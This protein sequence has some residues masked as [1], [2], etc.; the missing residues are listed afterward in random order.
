MRCSL[1]SVA[2][3]LLYHPDLV[4]LLSSTLR[5]CTKLYSLSSPFNFTPFFRLLKDFTPGGCAVLSYKACWL[6]GLIVLSLL[7]VLVAATNLLLISSV[8]CRYT[9][10][11]CI[12]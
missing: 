4:L 7:I 8:Q 2:L 12:L 11:D 1:L 5:S 10:C 9:Y 6:C 3:S